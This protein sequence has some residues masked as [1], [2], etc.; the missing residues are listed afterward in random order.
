MTVFIETVTVTCGLA[1][2]LTL[3]QYKW[4]WFVFG[5][6]GLAWVCWVFAG[7]GLLAAKKAGRDVFWAYVPQVAG[8]GLWLILYVVCWCVSDASNLI[9]PDSEFIYYGVL[10]LI[11]K[12]GCLSYYVFVI[13]DVDYDRF[14]LF[15]SKASL[16]AAA[17]LPAGQPAAGPENNTVGAPKQTQ[18]VTT[19]EVNAHLTTTEDAEQQ[20]ANEA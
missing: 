6:C 19:K 14:G 3:S 18:D 10:D 1:G 2:A 4:G 17:Q 9:S 13:R 20:P 11:A 16:F 12:A 15:S 7:P 8:F 5:M